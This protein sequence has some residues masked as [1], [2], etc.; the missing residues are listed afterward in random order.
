MSYDSSSEDLEPKV[1]DIL[2]LDVDTDP[3]KPDPEETKD[4]FHGFSAHKKHFV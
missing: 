3:Y 4:Y 1:T 2:H